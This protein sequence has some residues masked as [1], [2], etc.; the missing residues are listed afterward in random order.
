MAYDWQRRWK[1]IDIG[2][3]DGTR[4]IANAR[5]VKALWELQFTSDGVSFDEIRHVPCLILLGEPGMGK[6][7]AIEQE[8]KLSRSRELGSLHTSQ[9]IDLSGSGSKVEVRDQLFGTDWFESWKLGKYG[10][11]LFIDSVDQAGIPPR[12]IVSVI[13]NELGNAVVGRLRLRLVCRDHDWSLS[14][15]DRRK[16]VWRTTDDEESNVRIYRL[17]PLDSEDIRIAAEAKLGDG[18][19]FLKQVKDADARALAEIPITLEMLLNE[20]ENLTSSRTELYKHGM[21]RL[22]RGPEA[23]EDLPTAELNRRIELAKRI[24]VTMVLARKHSVNTKEDDVHESSR[25]LAVSDLLPDAANHDEECLIRTTLK[26]ALFH[27]TSERTWAHQSFAEYLAAEFLSNENIPVEKILDMMLAPDQKF[28]PQL[29]DTLRWLIETRNDVLHEVIKR[30]PML[31]LTADVSHLND[32]EFNNLFTAVLSLD[33]PYIYSHETWNL[34]KFRASHPSAKS[35][36]LPYLIDTTRSRYLRRFVL[37]LLECLD[38]NEIDDVLVRLAL[39][40]EEDQVLRQLA[41]RRLQDVG[42][43]EA[44]LCLKPYIYGKEDDPED[45]L[46]GYALQA[47]WPDHMTAD[48][49]FNALARPKRENYWGSYKTFIFEGSIVNEL[50]AVDLPTA[51]RWVAAQPSHHDMSFALRDLPGKIMRKAWDN[52]HVSDVLVA[53]TRTAIEMDARFDGIFGGNAYDPR[54]NDEEA[55]YYNRFEREVVARRQVVTAALPIWRGKDTSTTHL[56]WGDQ[57]IVLTSDLEWLIELLD[58]SNESEERCQ[59][60]GLIAGLLGRISGAYTS[61]AEENYRFTVLVYCAGQRHTEL[62]ELTQRFFV[63]IFD[64]PE[65]MRSKESFYKR[66]ELRKPVEPAAIGPAPIKVINNALEQSESGEVWQWL[67]VMAGL[68]HFRQSQGTSG[69]LQ[70]DLT[71]HPEWLSFET[72]ARERILQAANTFVRNYELES[73]DGKEGWY[74]SLQIPHVEFAGYLSMFLLLKAGG[75]FID[76]LPSISWVR[77]AKIALWYPYVHIIENDGRKDHYLEIRRL[78]QEL[79]RRLHEAAPN[80]LLDNLRSLIIAKD[81]RDSYLG[82]ELEKVKH[83]CDSQLDDMLLGLLRKSTLSPKGQ[84]SILDF[85]LTRECA[86]ASRV[87]EA[88]ISNGYTNQN[89]K[90]LVVEFSAS[91]MTGKSEFNWTAVWEIFQNDDDL[92]RVIAEQVA[93]EDWHTAEFVEKLNAPELV[94]LFIWVEERYPTSEDPDFNG[95]HTV[96][97]REQVGNW[98][99]GIVAE[100]RKK[101]SRESL[102]GIR[103]I[104]D[105]FPKLEWLHFVRIDL[106]RAV[107]GLEWKPSSPREFLD[108][109]CETDSRVENRLK[110]PL[111]WLLEDKRWLIGILIVIL[112]GVVQ[113][114]QNGE[115]A[116]MSYDDNVDVVQTSSLTLSVPATEKGGASTSNG[117]TTTP[118]PSSA[119]AQVK[120][121]N[122]NTTSE[123]LQ[124]QNNLR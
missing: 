38:I 29:H 57:P 51:L 59:L 73:T 54:F 64:D 103:Q 95:I 77:W 63:A 100:L 12:K 78:Q 93:K 60:A 116:N 58:A 72:V 21:R 26:S 90:D 24:A 23:T 52:L 56:V 105:R 74:A 83:F 47:L 37:Q 114:R 32:D 70:P 75:E 104:L 35:V 89:E 98:R 17:A 124:I 92:G 55:M 31:V 1:P 110:E 120:G 11:T 43:A 122:V 7:Y 30:Q 9:F 69:L 13:A 14:L 42:S 5:E 87:A 61:T 53:F 16:R 46:K 65:N 102:D 86:E 66:Q 62:S 15:A 112:L 97:P 22:C 94:D 96:T 91:L 33:D 81:R 121:G 108:L 49:L 80:T 18:E 113:L 8:Y 111:N 2:G 68:E 20:P 115:R 118:M 107:E 44:K 123:A 10:L 85:L 28:A 76:R 71:D 40:N 67:N 88:I 119:S 19:Q 4:E 109:L 101:D 106:Q 84:R 39:D 82:Q 41:A 48:A 27:G 25:A 3:S 45:D 50:Q 6:T 99:N 79:I 117:D 36:L 34:R